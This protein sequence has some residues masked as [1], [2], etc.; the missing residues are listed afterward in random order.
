[1]INTEK[2]KISIFNKLGQFFNNFIS[3]FKKKDNQ[4]TYPS[5]FNGML[6]GLEELPNYTDL[7]RAAEICEST[8]EISRKRILLINKI[9]QI[10]ETLEE[11]ECY[12]KLTDEEAERL[13]KLLESF[14][15]LTK[16]RNTLRY[17]LTDFDRS[18]EY[19]ISLEEDANKIMPQLEDAEKKQRIFRHDISAVE[20]EKAALESEHSVLRKGL[21]FVNRL[22]GAMT[23]AFGGVAL[24]LTY[25]YMIN[26]ETIFIP[27]S[28]LVILL[29]FITVL[30]HVFRKRMVYELDLNVKKQ[31]RAV[32]ILNRKNVVFAYYTNYLNYEYRKYKISNAQM[33]KN[34]LKDYEHFKHL[35]SRIDK[36]RDILYETHRQIEI[37]LREYNISDA[38]FTIEQ[39][40]QTV[41]IEDK[42]QFYTQKQNESQNLE[43]ELDELDLKHATLWEEL[44]ELNGRDSTTD[45]IIDSMIQMYFSQV[46]R[47]LAQVNKGDVEEAS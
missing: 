35:T 6:E 27:T 39:F 11:L 29:I 17:Q 26:Q 34:N 36:I 43:K 8:L 46:S 30:V 20:G 44:M 4:I 9:S 23:I 45:K 41:N 19:M 28:I 5:I 13:K 25:S 24:F 22:T 31:K 21:V 40:A 15:A 32:Q 38:K 16:E 47:F 1:M 2:E 7:V 42:K 33:L 14:V 10:H 18:L 3:S 37:F 12:N